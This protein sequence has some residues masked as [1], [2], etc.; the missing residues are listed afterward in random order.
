MPMLKLDNTLPAGPIDPASHAGPMPSPCTGICQMDAST[1][2]CKGCLRTLDEIIDWG[3]A[4]ESKKREV[5]HA[6]LARRAA[7]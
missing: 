6:I 5:W 4:P 2:L 1:G 7:Q 3:V